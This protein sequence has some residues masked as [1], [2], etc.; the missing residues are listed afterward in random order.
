MHATVL[1]ATPPFLSFFGALF[2]SLFVCFLDHVDPRPARL[3][4]A[5]LYCC[6][7]LM[8]LIQTV[9]SVDLTRSERANENG[10]GEGGGG[11]LASPNHLL[12]L[13]R[14]VEGGGVFTERIRL[15]TKKKQ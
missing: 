6:R 1:A 4:S 13:R 7:T 14:E 3:P 15:A 5:L 12:L 10:R 2:V 9:T 8:L 11:T